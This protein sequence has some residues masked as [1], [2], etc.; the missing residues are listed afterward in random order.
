M[1]GT[2]LPYRLPNAD[3]LSVVAATIL[4]AYA[5]ARLIQL[6]EIELATQLP[7]FY[8]AAKLNVQILTAFIVAGLTAAGADWLLRD[9]P[10]LHHRHTVEHWL[11]PA[12]TA[13]AIGLP[14]FQVPL[15]LTWWI[16][17]ALGGAMLILELL[18][19]YIV[20]DAQDERRGLA[21]AG[22]TAVSFALYLI[23]AASLHFGGQRLFLM[24]PTL[25]IASGLVS[26]RTLRLRQPGHWALLEAGLGAM[27]TAQVAAALHYWPI[28]S[29]AV[30]LGVLGPAYALTNLLGN[31]AEGDPLRQAIVEPVVVVI[32]IW[33]A[34]FWMG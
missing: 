27:T 1:T 4:L 5:I 22:L 3:R 23:L 13:W 26:L 19:E 10:A 15:S 17:F 21:A 8:L 32:L 31:L 18:A 25:A 24:L 34:A 11:L 20:V 14:L 30:G 16:G 7:G 28:Q 9:H 2:K 12:L 33:G 29:V 6:P